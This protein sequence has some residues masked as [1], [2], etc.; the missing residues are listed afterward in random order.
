M[1]IKVQKLSE[2]ELRE[3]G[4]FGWPV[5]EKEASEF[6]WHYD[7]C[8]QCYFLEGDVTVDAQGESV[9]FGKGDFVIFPKGLSCTWKIKKAVR[10][11]YQFK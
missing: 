5:W 3:K 1:Q 8:E 4:V 10:K 2:P 6:D 9:H 11:H 7:S